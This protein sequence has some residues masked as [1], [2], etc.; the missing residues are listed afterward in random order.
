MQAQAGQ[1]IVAIARDHAAATI[2]EAM[3]KTGEVGPD[4]VPVVPGARLAGLAYTV[5]CPAG[6]AKAIWHA[7]AEAPAGAV[8][9]VDNGGTPWMTAI[10]GTSVLA[11]RQRGLAGF[12]VNGAVRD[13][14][15]IREIGLPVFAAGVSLRG[16]QKTAEGWRGI[17]VAIGAAVIAPGDLV[18]GDDDGVVAVAAGAFAGFG[19]RVRARAAREAALDAR[20]MAGDHVLDAIGLR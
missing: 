4:I 16:T 19:E 10:G 7:I 14:S 8:I 9:V 5:R 2:Y 17:T 1:D 12:L 13:V 20:I 3:G 18:V 11:A 15:Q 6:D